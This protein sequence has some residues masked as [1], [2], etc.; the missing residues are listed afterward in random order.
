[1]TKA[2]LQAVVRVTAGAILMLALAATIGIP[3]GDRGL[4]A[5]QQEDDSSTPMAGDATRDLDS[6][7]RE[8]RAECV[9]AGLPW[10]AL[11]VDL[12]P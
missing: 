11:L 2:F 3:A 9:R 10:C 8:L 1:M 4:V 7:V 12:L 5:A 6:P